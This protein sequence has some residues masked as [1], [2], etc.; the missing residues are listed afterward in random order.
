M[1]PSVF[2]SQ[3]LVFHETG[4]DAI[5]LVFTGDYSVKS[6][7]EPYTLALTGKVETGLEALVVEISPDQ[8]SYRC[9]QTH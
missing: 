1:L 8:V 6:V 4:C 3:P 2:H 9:L 7:H 5:L